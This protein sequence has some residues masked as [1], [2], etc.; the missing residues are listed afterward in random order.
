MV[1][2]LVEVDG[3]PVEKRSSHKQTQGG[4]KRAAR[5]AKS[6]G[7]IVEE[8]LYRPGSRPTVPA[9]LTSVDLQIPLVRA[10]EPTG[11]LPD[12]QASREHL[13]RA[14]VSLP[15]EGLGLS[16]GEPAIPTRLEPSR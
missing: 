4:E 12:L 14:L 9:H 7:T 1:Y 5:L 11:A 8:V 15:W 13:R 2:K 3:I 6:S 10:G 16:H